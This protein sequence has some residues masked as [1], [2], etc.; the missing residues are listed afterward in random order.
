MIMN[1]VDGRRLYVNDEVVERTSLP[2]IPRRGEYRELLD[3]DAN[4]IN[5]KESFCVHVG[6][7]TAAILAV[8][9]LSY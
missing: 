5:V 9:E 2:T 6:G 7:V 3:A 8:V 1:P 4:N